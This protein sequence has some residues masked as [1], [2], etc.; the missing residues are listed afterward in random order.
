MQDHP[1]DLVWRDGD[2][3]VSTRFDDPYFSLENGL[4]ETRHVFLAG[5]DLPARFRDGFHIAELG[6]GTGLNL[7]AALAAWRAAGV[8]GRLHY[9][10]FEAWPVA[11]ADMRRAQTRFAELSAIAA[12]LAPF[13]QAQTG[14]IERPDLSFTLVTGDARR[15]LSHWDGMAD[16]WFLD[17]FSPAKNPAL[18]QRE[19]M[20]E[21]ARHTPMGGTAAT[22]TAA[23]FVRRGLA[24]AGFH[25][26]RQTGFGRKRH[27][28]T[29]VKGSA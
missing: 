22:Y 18:W 19:L 15:T 13:W 1:A 17:G 23:G 2:V 20:A 14:R 28:T 4:A 24:E 10:S 6:F 9:T 3:P 27:M 5:N 26:T 8:S 12:E 29:A 7:L 21:V 16:A 25:V 11:P